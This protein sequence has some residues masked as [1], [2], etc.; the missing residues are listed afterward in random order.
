MSRW[1]TAADGSGSAPAN[2][3]AME[4]NAIVIQAGHVID[5][6]LDCSAWTVGFQTFT[7]QGHA[8]TP[9]TL[10]CDSTTLSAGTY[11]IKMKTG[12]NIAGTTGAVRGG[13]LSNAD[14][15][16]GGTGS[17]A[18]DRKFIISLLGTATID[19]TYLDINLYDTE[20]ANKWVEVYKTAYVCADQTTGVNPAT[21]IITFGSAPPAAGTPVMVRSSGALPTG[22]TATDIYYIRT[23]SGNTC[24]LALQNSDA[25]I[26]DITATGSGALTMYDGW[27]DITTNPAIVN[28]IQNVTADSWS[29]VAGHNACVLAD[30]NAPENCD[31]QRLTIANIAAGTITLSS[32]VDSVQ[33]P[34]A[35]I[36]L[37]S[38]N[39]QVLSA[40]TSASQAIIAAAS[41]CVFKCEI[42]NTA[43]TGTTFYGYGLGSSYNN[44]ISGVVSGCNIGLGSSYNNIISGIVSGCNYG[45]GSSYNNIISGIVSGCNYGLNASYNNT[46][47]GVVSGCSY[48]INYSHN[49]TISGIVSGCNYGTYYSYNND[50]SGVV[51]G[52][53]YGINTSYNN[54]ISGQM[55]GNASDILLS[56]SSAT[57][58]S[59]LAVPTLTG[60]N[61]NGGAGRLACEN[62]N[63]GGTT[64]IYDCFGD[65]TKTACDGTGTAP[66]VDPDG[67]HGYCIGVDNVQSFLGTQIAGITNK[68]TIFS[69][70]RIWMTAGAHTITYKLQTTY[71]ALASGGLV[72]TAQYLNASG[73]RVS[74]TV[75][76]AIAQ[77]ANA[78]DWTQTIPITITVGTAGW[79]DLQLDL[80]Q[81][82]SGQAV[83]AWPT[84]TVSGITFALRPDWSM[85]ESV[86]FGVNQAVQ[87]L[88]P[89]GDAYTIISRAKRLSA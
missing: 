34:L 28:V 25:A 16:Y 60:R 19:A 87:H 73:V 1:N 85:G 59:G 10:R 78:A 71:A 83:Y 20:P 39:I 46:I 68:L 29:N 14:G 65:I 11:C 79:V 77:R 41:Y 89:A 21:D 82:E 64:K 72:L 51:S 22:L 2:F 84:P 15:N 81:Y 53:S 47:S 49:N 30:C 75:Q 67:A 9:G 45:L 56:N 24:K 55:T 74:A 70:H 27:T 40:G 61:T 3:A 62:L 38:R 54:I 69:K 26:V 35:R 66:S 80:I 36:Y 88:Y 18:Y 43:G 63:R 86:I 6:D 37:S 12:Y 23:V 42:R 57:L 32:N 44:I 76:P 4:D 31:Q 50:I 8:T 33:Y 52:C 7:I 5:W 17:L 48:G 58:C 13:I